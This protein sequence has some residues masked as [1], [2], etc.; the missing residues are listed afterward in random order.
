MSLP[1]SRQPT[2]PPLPGVIGEVERQTREELEL[3]P[4]AKERP[5]IAAQAIVLAQR[6]DDPAFAAVAATN[7]RQLQAL[8]KELQG[9]KRKSGGRLHVVEAMSRRK[10]ASQ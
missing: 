1:G 8:L 3:T 6:L 10:A 4:K 7:S 5:S 2:T 9:P